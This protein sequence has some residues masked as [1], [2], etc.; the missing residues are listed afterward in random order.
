MPNENKKVVQKGG[1]YKGQA[2]E[3]VEYNPNYHKSLTNQ[4]KTPGKRVPVSYIDDPNS[5]KRYKV[6]GSFDEYK[7]AKRDLSKKDKEQ[8]PKVQSNNNNKQSSGSHK[9][10]G[11]FYKRLSYR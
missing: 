11:K 3:I 9:P 7:R 5:D 8:S 1:P 10:A 4:T 2:R 6:Y